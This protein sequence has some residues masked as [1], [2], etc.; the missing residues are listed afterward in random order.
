M[1]APTGTPQPIMA[2]LH[3]EITRIMASDDVRK[4]LIDVGLVPL[5]NSPAEFAELIR[6]ETPYWAALIKELGIKRID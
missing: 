5:G 6:T 1:F 4:R 3:R 2:R